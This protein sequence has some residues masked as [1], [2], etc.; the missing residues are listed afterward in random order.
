[1]AMMS[2]RAMQCQGLTFPFP[3]PVP[4]GEAYVVALEKDVR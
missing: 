1:M 4:M 2:V 3:N